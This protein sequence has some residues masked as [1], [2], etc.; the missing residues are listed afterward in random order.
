MESYKV[1]F[2]SAQIVVRWLKCT[3]HRPTR[4]KFVN[5]ENPKESKTIPFDYGLGYEGML[6]KFILDNGMQETHG[7]LSI[8]CDYDCIIFAKSNVSLYHADCGLWY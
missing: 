2:A 5:A 7:I 3:N 1:S 6:R 4:I 8:S